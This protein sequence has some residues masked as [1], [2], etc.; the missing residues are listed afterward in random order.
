MHM[1]QQAGVVVLVCG[2]HMHIT[3]CI[4]MQLHTNKDGA[5]GA[6]PADMLAHNS[7]GGYGSYSRG[8]RVRE[9]GAGGAAAAAV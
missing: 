7:A 8:A 2:T 9:D 3:C 5:A 4:R 6:P 1:Q